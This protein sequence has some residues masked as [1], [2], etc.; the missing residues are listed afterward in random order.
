MTK[1][2]VVKEKLVKLDDLT[3]KFWWVVKKNGSYTLTCDGHDYVTATRVDLVDL[4]DV[5]DELL[6][7][8]DEPCNKL[9]LFNT[10]AMVDGF[11]LLLALI[12]IY[13]Y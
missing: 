12:G 10:F 9:Y 5:V 7:E 4:N 1:Y 8:Q 11:T 3:G 6:S 13:L 2:D